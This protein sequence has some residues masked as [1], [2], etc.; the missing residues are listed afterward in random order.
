MADGRKSRRRGVS[1]GLCATLAMGLVA[2]AKVNT[3]AT[4]K[5]TPGDG[6]GA[7]ISTGGGTDVLGGTETRPILTD[8]NLPEASTCTS[9]VTCNPPNGQYCGVIGN[10]CSGTMNCSAPCPGDQVCEDHVCVG[11]AACMPLVCQVATGKYCGSVGNG[12]GR[13][14]DCGGCAANQTCSASGLCVT[15]GCVP[16]TCNVGISRYCG[17]VGDGC[18]GTLDCGAC[19]APTTCGGLGVTGVCGDPNCKKIT[20]MPA[21]GG[22]YCG[23][24][25]DGC[26]GT[27][28]CGTACP[29]GMACGAAPPG[30]GA[31][32]SNVCPGSMTTGGCTGLACMVPKCTGTATTSISGIVRDPAG[33]L[34]LYNVVVYV[35]NAPLAAVPEGVSCDRCSVALSGSPIAT[36]LTDINGRFVL[37]GV[38]AGTGLPAGSGIPVVIQVGKWRRQITVPNVTACVDNPITNADLTR[39]PRTKGEGNIPKIAV[40]TGGSDALECLVRRIGI[41]DSEFTTDGGAGRVHLY[42]GGKGT[43]S[44]M[45]GGAFAPAT[46]L[47]SSPTKLATYDIVVMSCEGSTSEFVAMKPQTSVENVANYANAGGR[48]FLSHLHFYWPQKRIPDFSSTAVYAGT[49]TPPTA[50]SSETIAL[51]INQTF[52]KG[53]ALAQWLAGPVVNATPT[54]GMITVAGIEHSV[55]GVNPPTTEWIYL[56]R[57]A[58]DTQGRRSSQYLSFNTPVGTPEAM[59]CGKV[60]FTDIH[61]GQSVGATGGDDSDVSKPFPIGTGCKA[62][63]MSPQAKALEFLFFD[64]SACVLPDNTVPVPPPVPPPGLPTTPP[65]VTPVPP[66]I[67]PPPPPPPPPPIM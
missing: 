54:P 37:S 32:V 15:A 58:R 42:A 39:L 45:A 49:I 6:G 55:T 38:P 47:W 53:M 61:I 20:C 64:L 21:G 52:P 57:N 62:T 12:C 67:P 7:D 59:Q 18:G 3:G 24:I 43:N 48:L 4:P 11:S 46:A 17:V 63:D 60:V 65:P 27:L 66:P 16:L 31:G 51:T 41:A 8:A 1:W 26:G 23:T 9:G 29:M 44:F 13:A 22:Q 34:P 40:T 2:C 35:P 56:P 33:K 30:G 19:A 10:G 14:M 25:G 36:A 5:P 28:D 50:E